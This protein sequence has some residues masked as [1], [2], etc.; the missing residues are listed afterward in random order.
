MLIILH[1]WYWHFRAKH[2]NHFS[3]I[4]SRLLHQISEAHHLFFSWYFPDV[5][6]K[7]LKHITCMVIYPSNTFQVFAQ[8]S[9]SRPGTLCINF[10]TFLTLSEHF[11]GAR[12]GRGRTCGLKASTWIWSTVRRAKPRYFQVPQ[13]FLSAQ[14]ST[15]R[16]GTSSINFSKF[17]LVEFC[18]DVH[19]SPSKFFF[20]ALVVVLLP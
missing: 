4:F 18:S 3:N 2:S 13:I 10:S 6:T 9:I 20:F 5:C 17:R 8:M 11:E 7:F 19:N 15:S 12:P 16:P 14:I 1:W